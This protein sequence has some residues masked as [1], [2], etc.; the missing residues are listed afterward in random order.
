MGKK[1]MG[2]DIKKLHRIKNKGQLFNPTNQHSSYYIILA[3]IR[4]AETPQSG[5]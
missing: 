2:G 4:D 5:F 1:Q 3:H